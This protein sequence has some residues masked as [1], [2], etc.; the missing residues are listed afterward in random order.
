[1]R[2]NR[3]I[4]ALLLVIVLL[5][6]TVMYL[7]GQRSAGRASGD[8]IGTVQ[9]ADAGAKAAEAGAGAKAEQTGLEAGRERARLKRAVRVGTDGPYASACRGIGSVTNLPGGND[10]F[11]SVRE[12]PSARA[13]QTDK[14]GDDAPV[15]LCDQNE[16]GSWIGIVYQADGYVPVTDEC[17]VEKNIPSRRPYAGPCLSGWVSA[18]YIEVRTQG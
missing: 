7:F 17:R 2:M 1:M 12:G 9:P 8:D 18:K 15:F 13:R 10:N 6:G 14:L 4:V 16:D 3:T 11:L 5:V